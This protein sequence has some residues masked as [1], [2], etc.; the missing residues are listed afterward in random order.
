MAPYNYGGPPENIALETADV[1]GDGKLD[2]VLTA[3]LIGVYLGNGDGT[4]S[5]LPNYYQPMSSGSAGIAIADFNSDGKPDIAADGEVLLGNGNGRFQGPPTVLLPSYAGIAVVVK[6]V[7]NTA[8][9]IAAI[10]SNAPNTLYILTNDGTGI[11]SLAHTYTLPQAGYVIASA[12]LNGDGNADLVVEGEDPTSRDWSYMVLLGNGDGSFQQAVPHQQPTQATNLS[13][14]IVIAD[15]NNDHKPDLAF[16]QGSSTFAVL[17]GNGDGTFGPATYVFDGDG[18]EIVSGDF[19][20]DGNLDIAETGP[21]GVAIVLGTGNGAFGNATFP[22]TAGLGKLIAGGLNGDGNADLVGTAA[23][24]QVLL[25]NGNGT[26]NALAPFDPN[27]QVSAFALA[28]FDGDGKLDVLTSEGAGA[29]TTNSIFLGNG[30]GT[31]NPT[32]FNIPYNYPPHSLPTNVQVADM[33]G[34]GKPD[35]IIESGI[36]T[37]FVLLN[38]TVPVP[39][40][41]TFAM[42][43]GASNSST[44]TAGQSATF[45]LALTPARSFTGTVNLTCGIT[46][47]LTPAPLCSLPGSVN[48]AGSA[49][50]P[51]TV[52]FSTTASSSTGGGPSTSFPTGIGLVSWT[53]VLFASG[54]VFLASRRRPSVALPMIVLSLILMVGCGGSKSSSSSSTHTVMGTPAG[55]Y[56]ATITATSGSLGHQ[57][58]LNVIVQ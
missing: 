25:G 48:L 31:F 19:N 35:L 8:P 58:V 42:A 29:V 39:P 54:L 30:D 9:G 32:Q 28:D 12:D 37:I 52:T 55:T 2:L 20:N 23:G 11:L 34:D 7:K 36:S 50:T 10:P 24:I 44:I 14:P 43:S 47:T 56:T 17:L 16:S 18:G 41:F 57:V 27:G 21:S 33:N 5:N 4:F 15:F 22:S 1:N 13:F 26:F 6:F 53:L 49:A 51:V 40:D 46:P 45:N 3:D 38:S